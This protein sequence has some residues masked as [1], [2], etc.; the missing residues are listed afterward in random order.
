MLKRVNSDFIKGIK[1]LNN[2]TFNGKEEY[3]KSRLGSKEF[4]HSIGLWDK[5]I[6]YVKKQLSN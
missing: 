2:K 5:Y 4:I 6:K 3:K 1:K